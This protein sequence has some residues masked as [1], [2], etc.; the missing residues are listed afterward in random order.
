MRY[1]LD[2]LEVGQ[3]QMRYRLD[4]LEVGQEQIYDQIQIVAEGV[5]TNSVR[6]DRIEA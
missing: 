1:R 5:K 6:L 3:D 2:K 4:K